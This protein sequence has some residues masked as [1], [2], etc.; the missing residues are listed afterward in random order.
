MTERLAKI[1]RETLAA[2]PGATVVDDMVMASAAQRGDTVYTSDFG[3]L[4]KLKAP[5]SRRAHPQ[6][7]DAIARDDGWASLRGLY[8]GHPFGGAFGHLT[9][10]QNLTAGARRLARRRDPERLVA[11]SRELAAKRPRFGYRRLHGLLRREGRAV[12]RK[13]VG[14][15][16]RRRTRRKL[17]ASRPLP[18]VTLTRPNERWSMDFVHDSL[19]DGRRLRTLNVID[20]F[21]RE[22]LAIEVD[23]SLPPARVTRVLD[24]LIW[25]Y[26]LPEALRVDN[27]PEFISTAL[28]RWAFAHGVAPHFIQPGKPVQ[29]AHVETFNGHFRDECISPAHW[30]TIA[31]ARVEAELWRVDY[32]CMRPHS[33]L[34]YETTKAFGDQARRQVRDKEAVESIASKGRRSREERQR[35]ARELHPH[36]RSLCSAE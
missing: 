14:L 23:T 1:A 18:P 4:S 17:R 10:A 27:G 12:N 21:T 2:V 29:N 36:R 34:R 16:V 28:D 26:V 15:A 11:R 25:E 31:R 30:P 22:C 19:T 3:D 9:H 8:G 20:A 5:L 7:P 32:N 33:S 24:R 35:V 13:L 6:R